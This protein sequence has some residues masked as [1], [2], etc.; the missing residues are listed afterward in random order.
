MISY[1]LIRILNQSHPVLEDLL[2]GTIIEVLQT[3]L[4]VL[5]KHKYFDSAGYSSNQPILGRGYVFSCIIIFSVL[6]S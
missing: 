3:I 4:Q 2:Q 5:L 6:C 1:L